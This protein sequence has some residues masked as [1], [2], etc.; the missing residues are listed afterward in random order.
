MANKLRIRCK[1]IFGNFANAIWF[2]NFVPTFFCNFERKYKDTY[3][4]KT[5]FVEKRDVLHCTDPLSI[6]IPKRLKIR[7]P[8]PPLTQGTPLASNL[9]HFRSMF[10]FYILENIKSEH[11]CEI[12]AFCSRFLAWTKALPSGFLVE[13]LHLINFRYY[14]EVIKDRL[15]IWLQIRSAFIDFYSSWIRQKREG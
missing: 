6:L 10:H 11:W 14:S 3:V 13:T 8:L 15:Q 2:L 9:I 12:S 4:L 1:S 5:F 7:T